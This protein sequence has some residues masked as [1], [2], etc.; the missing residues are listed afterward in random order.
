MNKEVVYKNSRFE[1]LSR[2]DSD[3]VYVREFSPEY[4]T[5]VAL[6]DGQLVVVKQHREAMGQDTYELPGGA[7]EAGESREE[8]ARRELREETGYTCGELVPLGTAHSYACIINRLNHLFFTQEILGQQEQD[9]DFDED[10][11][12]QTYPVDDAFELIKNGSWPDSELSQALLLA[13]LNGL[14]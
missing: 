11:E 7:M 12:I 14:L 3:S 6:K 8:A 9:L 10:I 4:V 1:I 2:S 13:R 5:V